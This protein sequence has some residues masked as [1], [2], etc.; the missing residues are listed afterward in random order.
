MS[1]VKIAVN[2]ESGQF[3]VIDDTEML[4]TTITQEVVYN[5]KQTSIPTE[6]DIE[7]FYMENID[8]ALK[9]RTEGEDEN[10]YFESSIT[11]SDL[12]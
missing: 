9:N 12:L 3:V 10:G 8:I 2:N 6:D 1:N 7:S 5:K 4:R 11:E